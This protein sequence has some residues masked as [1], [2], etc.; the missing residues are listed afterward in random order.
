[1]KNTTMK[2]RVVLILLSFSAVCCGPE[3]A[4][5]AGEIM[6]EAGEVLASSNIVGAQP[7]EACT[8]TTTTTTTT[9]DLEI[10][11]IQREPAVSAAS[12]QVLG[13][14]AEWSVSGTTHTAA[15][16]EGPAFINSFSTA[17]SDQE[18]GEEDFT[19]YAVTNGDC[20]AGGRPLVSVLMRKIAD[21]GMN[22]AR[23]PD[24]YVAAGETLCVGFDGTTNMGSQH[25]TFDPAETQASATGFRPY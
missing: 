10:T 25:Q 2:K 22:V 11:N 24:V 19:L 7:P 15:L 1:M 3:F 16:L 4:N 6:L 18:Y 5:E 12:Q 21:F 9:G 13:T 8:T 14:S 23:F 20:T 17:I